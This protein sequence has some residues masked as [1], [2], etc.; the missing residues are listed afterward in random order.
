MRWLW[1]EQEAN[2]R[3]QE[4]EQRA[5]WYVVMGAVRNGQLKQVKE[6]LREAVKSLS[7]SSLQKRCV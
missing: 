7:E 3:T 4:E 6:V 5:G 1:R 2:D